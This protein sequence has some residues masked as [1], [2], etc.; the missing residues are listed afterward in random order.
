MALAINKHLAPAL[1]IA[2]LLLPAAA[3][4]AAP[5]VSNV[6]FAQ[7]AG[8]KLVDISYDVTAATPT[9]NVALEISRDGGTTLSVP[10]TTVSGAIGLGV[11]PGIGKII[12]WDADADWSGQYGTQM[13]YK[14]TATEPPV[15]MSLIPAGA[16]TMGASLDGISDAP[17]RTVT[18]SAFYMGQMEVTKAEWD[19][20][21]A[22]AVSNG[23]TDLS[24]G[25]GKA[26]NHPVQTVNWFHVIKWCNARSEKE[27]LTPCYTVSGSVMRTGSAAPTVNWAANGYRLPTEAEWEKAARGG[28]S[29][30]R[31]P[32]G[33]TISHIQANYK[34]STSYSYDISP[35]LYYHPIYGTGSAPYTS[36]VGSFTANGYGLQDM[37]GN[38][39]EWCWDRY[40]T[41][42]VGAQT[43]PRGAAS[44][45]GRVLRGGGWGDSNAS[46]CRTA[47]RISYAP[48]GYGPGADGSLGFRTARSSVLAAEPGSGYAVSV[49]GVVDT[50]YELTSVTPSNGS[51]SGVVAD[52]KYVTG[53][54][55][56]LTVVPAAG[57]A[58]TGWTGAASGTVDPLSLLMNSDKSIG[59]TFT[60]QYT[61]TVSALS[62][63]TISGIAV[64]GKYLTG[65][66]ATLTA[67][68]AA[69]YAFTGWTGAG[70]GTANPLLVLMDADTPIGANFTPDTSDTDN[71]GLT[72]YQ[73][74]VI[75]GTNASLADTDGDGI[76]DGA[77]IAQGRDPLRSEPI[78]SNLTFVQRAGTKLVDI[79]YN[80]T[81]ATP[82]VNV[83]LEISSDGGTT[84]S[85]PATSVSGAIGAGVTTGTGKTIT[86]NTGV[87]WIG[88]YSTR[89]RYK[90][91]ATYPPVG[92]SLIPAGSFTMGDSLDGDSNASPRTVTLSAFYIGR[93]EV[94]KAEWDAVKVWA[95]SNG[96]ADLS[97]GAGKAVDHPVQTVTWWDVIKW[98]NAR[99]EKEGLTP[100]YTVGGAVMKTGNTAPAVNWAATGYRLPTEAEWEKAARGGLS[101]KRFP[102]GDAI[103]QTEA[104]F[105]N[106]GGEIYQT[107]T[108]GYH[109]SY[110]TGSA[111][112]TSP[113]GSFTANGYGLHDVTGNVWEWCWD[114]FG[115]Y[116]PGAQTDPRGASSGVLRAARGGSWYNVAG[117]CRVAHRFYNNPTIASR[118]YGFRSARSSALATEAASGYAVSADGV[119]DT[120]YELTSVTPTNGTISVVVADGKYL[121]GTTATL[122]AVPVAGYAFT[123]WTGAA[124]GTVNPLPLLM[125]SDKTIGATFTRQYTLTSDPLVNGAISGMTADGKY[126]TGTNATLTAVP[127]AGYAFTGWTGAANGTT[128]PLALV[129]NGDK[130]IGATFTRQYMLTSGPLSNGMITGTAAGG[131]YLTGTFATLTAVPA[132][133]YAFTGWTGDA[134]G[135]SN[136]L[137][138]LM[139]ADKTIGANF[140]RQYTLTVSALSNGSIGGSAVDG[141][142]LT[143]TTAT[144]TAI[145][146]EGYVFTGWTG[147]AWGTTNPLSLVMNS[148]KTIGAT[149]GS[150][151]EVL[152][153]GQLPAGSEVVGR[154]SVKVTMQTAFANGTI[155]YTLDGS[156][157]SLGSKLYTTALTIRR[158]CTVRAVAYSSDFSITMQSPP[159]AVVIVPVLMAT[160]PGGGGISVEPPAGAYAADVMATLTATPAAGWTFL[161][162][163]GD[164]SGTEPVTRVQMARNKCVQAVFGTAVNTTTV[165]SGSIWQNPV[166]AFYPY[167]TR[168]RFSGLPASGNYLAFWGNAVTSTDNP[169]DFPVTS[170]NQTV[171]AVFQ[172][173]AVGHLGGGRRRDGVGHS[174]SEP[175]QQWSQYS[176]NSTGGPGAGVC[177]LERRCGGI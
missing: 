92:M 70:S 146:A 133:G 154:G 65:T 132:Q 56:T 145:P 166:A 41:Y 170:P 163:L 87:D 51:I 155:L 86:W 147:A 37:A 82:T 36:P 140:T 77:E 94:T 38:V 10:A 17:L 151:I 81:A 152:V 76:N 143:G 45:S 177:R 49:A 100:C 108:T 127:A 68:P 158:S 5:V 19:A 115:T 144:L 160:T 25:A 118:D 14:V 30:K 112:Y 35:T 12:T 44:G 119:V 54:T 74:I 149:Y 40:G 161:Q 121:T 109:P 1:G 48:G 138:L 129:M 61:L 21:R 8:T 63:G 85:V 72:S 91:T 124:S 104:N 130:S 97:V 102:W 150:G 34:S 42:A 27:G 88:Q 137:S 176:P 29:G 53:T 126:L 120:R 71:D 164:A 168:I 32:L 18:L 39:W 13:R 26:P 142:Y 23:Y 57:Y 174:G 107:G 131:K 60:R 110:G 153:D 159:L 99:S 135:T 172:P 22:W 4:A 175:I 79:S 58:F 106:I 123:G 113:V 128:N 101:G 2:L 62:N 134:S 43:D 103:S 167:G 64:D 33:D 15:G 66:T 84:F 20:V 114:W 90:V 136:P 173:L 148:D 73:E 95:V 31:F 165:G 157:P 117:I 46:Y 105:Q 156:E 162:W 83:L 28:L 6:T 69:G 9:V 116:A 50:R 98:C 55:A 78:V 7:R 52:G 75:Y 16:F 59:A 171:T 47:F 3:H 11:A 141:K 139:N 125:N 89:M 111:P 96:Y 24:G 169:L 122:T 80:V 93:K 67:V